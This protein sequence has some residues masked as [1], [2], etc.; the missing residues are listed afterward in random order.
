MKISRIRI[1][2]L[3]VIALCQSTSAQ[4]PELDSNKNEF[5]IL[6]E[7]QLD[8]P[9]TATAN[10]FKSV[11][12]FAAATP[13]ANLNE[14]GQ[15]IE[16]VP[17]PKKAGVYSL[18]NTLVG[19]TFYSRQSQYLFG[20]VIEPPVTDVNDLMFGK[21]TLSSLST[22]ASY[23]DFAS[24]GEGFTV[25]TVGAVPDPW[26]PWEYNDGQWV[27]EGSVA[28]NVTLSSLSFNGASGTVTVSSALSAGGSGDHGLTTGET[29]TIS[30]ASPSGY[31]GTFDV[32]S[33]TGLDSFTFVMD[34]SPSEV[35][36]LKVTELK[37]TPSVTQTVGKGGT[38]TDPVDEGHWLS[39]EPY[40]YNGHVAWEWWNGIGGAGPITLLSDNARY[41]DSPDGVTF[42]PSWNTR[43][44][45]A[46]G[47]ESNGRDNYGGR[48]S[49]ILTAP[50]TGTYRFFVASDD[51]SVL[52]ISTD[53]DPANAVQ[54]AQETGCCKNFTLDDG[55]LSGTVNL[56]AGNQ[57]YM[58]ALLKEGSGG[59]WMTVGWR[60]PSED[61]DD[62]PAG[63]QEGIPGEYFTSTVNVQ[64]LYVRER[65][66]PDS[67][68][69]TQ[70]FFGF[71]LSGIDTGTRLL[72][73]RL[74]VHQ[75]NKI[76]DLDAVGYASDL[77]LS[78][79]SAAWD[80]EGS[81]YPIFETTTTEDAF[82]IGNDTQFGVPK[83]SAG[84]FGGD[85]DN[86]ESDDGQIDVTEFVQ[87][88]LENPDDNHGFRLRM[89]DKSFTGATFSPVDNPETGDNEE[90]RLIITQS[91]YGDNNATTAGTLTTCRDAYHDF[92]TSPNYVVA[93]AGEVTLSVE[94][95]HAFEADMLDSGQLW[96]SVNGRAYADVE[97]DAFSANGYTNVAIAGNGIAKGENGFGGTSA[98]YADGSYITTT[99][100]LGTFAAGDVISVRFV[101]LYGDCATG[102]KPNWVIDKVAFSSGASGTVTAASA[103]V[104]AV[105]ASDHGLS[106]G[107]AFTISGASPSSYNGTF[108][109]ASNTGSDSFIFVMDSSPSNAITAGTLT[110]PAAST[111]PYDYWR[112]KPHNAYESDLPTAV[113]YGRFYWSDNSE[114]LYATR[115]GPVE[116]VWVRK[117]PTLGNPITGE[118]WSHST[119]PNSE[120]LIKLHT[121]TVNGVTEMWSE[122]TGI[123]YP[124]VKKQVIISGSSVKPA[125]KIYWTGSQHSGVPVSIPHSRISD[126]K[127]IFNESFPKNVPTDEAEVIFEP[128]IGLDNSKNEGDSPTTSGTPVQTKTLWY[129]KVQNSINAANKEGRVFVELLGTKKAGAKWKQSLGFEIVD[130]IKDPTLQIESVELGE[131]FP[132]L[133]AIGKAN[134]SQNPNL[135]PTFSSTTG[136]RDFVNL[137]YGSNPSSRATFYAVKETKND[138]DLML[139]WLAE[140]L[141]GIK[142]PDRYVEYKLYW[143]SNPNKY[144]HYIRPAVDSEADAKKTA[145]QLPSGNSPKIAYQDDAASPRAKLDG[146]F[147]FYTYL[148]T[149]YPVHRTLLKYSSNDNLEF[150][151]VFSWLEANIIDNSFPTNTITGS[152]GY[153]NAEGS[154][155]PY[156]EPKSES[157]GSSG[158]IN[159]PDSLELETPRILTGS[160]FVGEA[161]TT[162]ESELGSGDQENYLAAYINKGT[163]YDPVSYKNPFTEGFDEA[164][165]GAVIPVNAIPG[166]NSLEV[167]WFRKNTK[168]WL[169]KVEMNA[170][171]DLAQKNGFKDVY[172]PSVIATYTIKWPHEAVGYM[173]VSR[174]NA[175]VMA[176]NDGSGPLNSLQAKGSLYFQNNITLPGHNPNEE[177]AIMQ[178]GQVYALRN[179]L[180][181]TTETYSSSPYVLLNYTGADGR[182]AMRAFH[183]LQ[184]LGEDTFDY[185][186]EAGTILQAPMPLPLMQK[187]KDNSEFSG[188]IITSATKIGATHSLTLVTK[189][190]HGFSA[191]D[192]V[193]LSQFS[194][195]ALNGWAYVDNVNAA[196]IEAT[197]MYNTRIVPID[198]ITNDSGTVTVVTKEAH[199]FGVYLP[200]PR[201]IKIVGV[202]GYTKEYDNTTFSTSGNELVITADASLGNKG[203][204][205]HVFVLPAA[206]NF[207]NPS[208]APIDIGSD[209]PPMANLQQSAAITDYLRSTIMDRKN[210]VWVY[211]GPHTPSDLATFRMRY[212]YKTLKGFWFPSLGADQL[213]VG[214]VVPYLLNNKEGA[215]TKQDYKPRVA[216]GITYNAIWPN[217]V[218]EL[219]PGQTLTEPVFGLPAVRG[220]TSLKLLYQ[221]SKAQVATDF[222]ATLHDPTREKVYDLA[223]AATDLSELPSSAATYSSKGKT[224]FTHLPPHLVERFFFDPNR[225]NKGQL[226]LR[227]EFVDEIVGEDYLLMNVLSGKDLNDLKKV[228]DPN[229]GIRKWNAAIN[230]LTAKVETFKE[231]TVKAGVFVVDAAKTVNVTAAN[232]V[233]IVSDET[234]VDSYALTANGNKYGYVTLIAGNS[235]AHTPKAEPVQMHVI[236]IDGPLYRGEA[237]V[238]LSDNPL[239]E[240]VTLM[241]TGDMGGATNQF[242]YD[243]RIASPE[244]GSPPDVSVR[245]A[246]NSP[247]STSTIINTTEWNH[248]SRIPTTGVPPDG[249]VLWDATALSGSVTVQ[250]SIEA[251]EITFNP[252]NNT[253][254]I[255]IRPI[256][257]DEGR[258]HN[259]KVGDVVD[260]VGFIPEI[261][262]EDG[263]TVKSVAAEYPYTITLTSHSVTDLSGLVVQKL[264]IVEES[265][266]GT[267]ISSPESILTG[268][269]QI[270]SGTVPTDVYLSMAVDPNLGVR[271]KIGS[272]VVAVKNVSSIIDGGP[273]DSAVS[274]AP[275]SFNTKPLVYSVDTSILRHNGGVNKITVELWGKANP[276]A[277]L[278][279]NLQLDGNKLED[280]VSDGSEWISEQ[281]MANDLRSIVIGESADIRALSDNYLVMRYQ[282]TDSNH[283]TWVDDDDG[284]NVGWSRWTEPQLA[285]GWIKRVLAGINPFNQRAGDLY[286][287]P[288]RM[289]ASM[290]TQA[291]KRWEGDVALNMDNINDYGLIEIYETVLGRGR[292]LSIDAGIDFGPANDAL[293]LA[294]GYLN[295]LYMLIGNEAWADAA[296]PTIGIGTND[297]AYGDIATALFAF[298]GQ[299]PSLLEEEL[300]LLRGRDDFHQPGVETGPVYN[301]LF[302]NYTRGIDAGEVIYSLNYDIKENIDDHDG[303]IDAADAY[304]MYPQGHGD[305]YGHYLTA[306]KGYYKL[307]VD[308][309][310]TWV[311]RVEAVTILGKAVEV[312]YTDERKFAAAA[313]AA[314]RAG[315]EIVDLTWRKDYNADKIIV[316]DKEFSPSRENN[317]RSPATTRYW[318]MDHWASRVGQGALINWVVGNSMLP[319]IDPDPA[320]EGIEKIDR[321][322]V[323]E[324]SELSAVMNTVQTTMDNAEAGMNPLGLNENSV[325]MDISPDK[326]THFEQIFERAENA[327]NNATIAFDSAKDVTQLMRSE[328]DSLFDMEV[329]VEEQELAYKFK[330]IELYGTPYSGD[331]GPGKTYKQG[332]DGPDLYHHMYVDDLGLTNSI[333]GVFQPEQEQTFK[334]D[335]QTNPIEMNKA[336]NIKDNIYGGVFHQIEGGLLSGE[337]NRYFA[338]VQKNLSWEQY[339]ARN[340]D[341]YDL[342][343][344]DK[345]Y[346]TYTVSPSGYPI[347]PSDWGKRSTVGGLQQAISA[348]R[349][350]RNKLSGVL[351]AHERKKYDLDRQIEVF[352]SNVALKDFISKVKTAKA[353][354]LGV[355][356]A[357][358]MTRYTTE[359]TRDVALESL[360]GEYATIL[361]EIT[362]NTVIGMSTGGDLLASAKAA[363][364]AAE[365]AE[366]VAIIASYD[367]VAKG[368]RMLEDAKKIA[369]GVLDA[370]VG[371]ETKQNWYKNSVLPLDLKLKELNSSLYGIS[372][373]M[374]S[375]SGARGRYRNLL[376]QGLRIQEEREMFRQNTAVVVQSFRSK[377]AAFRI[378]RNEKLERYKALQETAAKYAF[379][380]AQAYDYET[381]LLGT[382]E[383]RMFINRIIN[384]RALGVVVNGKPQ[385]AGSDTGDPGISSVLAEMKNDWNVIKGR[386]GFNNP[387]Q[388]AT[389]LSLRNEKHRILPGQEGAAQWGDVLERARKDN[390]LNDG[391][392]RRYCMNVGFEDGRP[393]PGLVIEFSTT[394]N[395]GENVFGLPIVGGDNQFSSSSFA[396]K[397]WSAGIAFEGYVGMSKS[398][399]ND[400]GGVSPDN[401]TPIWLDPTALAKNPYVYLIPVGKDFMRSPP[402]GDTSRIR[403]WS[404][405][406]VAVPLPFNI[407]NSEYSSK[408]FWQSSN[409]LTEELFGIRKHQAFRALDSFDTVSPSINAWETVFD[410]S[411]T[412]RRLIGRSVWNSKW[413]I[414]IPGYTLLNDPEE[415][416]DRFIE[417]VDDIK[418]HF[419]TYSY[420]GN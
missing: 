305:S 83:N 360:R 48:M 361:H 46:G 82:I 348:V 141:Q 153:T 93:A 163:S 199:G 208:E 391:D 350:E 411:A 307:I 97:K 6:F 96:I 308:N 416:L 292:M 289:A 301:R 401:P 316:W 173:A 379:L 126:I 309:D 242:K 303:K 79:V 367:A 21:V 118:G 255:V 85:P 257:L 325:A 158:K 139:W 287:N 310:F 73:A 221:Q 368:I 223:Q 206:E 322:T 146:E 145:V 251:S 364:T 121:R 78:R 89:T 389:S 272:A 405:N 414:V 269:F 75:M 86:P 336:G 167:I 279:F 63:N 334:I 11:M 276:G 50:E 69:R 15:I 19:G 102:A 47:F 211:R 409:S 343:P 283:V 24:D 284:N 218:A 23:Y 362:D 286:T 230:G 331:I 108:V 119:A 202:D 164:N 402:L 214:T 252:D 412:N 176:S 237:K 13:G 259:F 10:Q 226:V 333:A 169:N 3:F 220:N 72:S 219:R 256:R 365:T 229:M 200:L 213:S 294:A 216:L 39:G 335:L 328:T 312:D 232:L 18:K 212:Y 236:K 264:G 172:W 65:S 265:V 419:N 134:I 32:A 326:G 357:L 22:S 253:S 181:D 188:S 112:A 155:T 30:G 278:L 190:D 397:I 340:A 31:N 263:L 129:S 168:R 60:K 311:P 415:G 184:E 378:F 225:G 238:I 324:L 196:E 203:V 353:I 9:V 295:D 90:L 87:Y 420:S 182:P 116:I 244:D 394:I 217:S 383:G 215:L 20:A 204:G 392:V 268:K 245:T 91:V 150:E 132:V 43:T 128:G 178:G 231:S 393:V 250:E 222:S 201:K 366:R 403:S 99:A 35:T 157:V 111:Q 156:F 88:W 407:G 67:P 138:S 171:H 285:E 191:N 131:P 40:T 299:V 80:T 27:S 404:V 369:D 370:S 161:L 262:N 342:T 395:K 385:F 377:D 235:Q 341:E 296:N 174:E 332:W 344:L 14:D 277:K 41:P 282:A 177:H 314:A 413:K 192:V 248:L 280:K 290:L 228:A 142:W 227:G 76:N 44:A 52:R 28:D 327:L 304:V 406:D 390:I 320:H 149:S 100:S 58:E 313:A 77:E 396:T 408:K 68:L 114:A 57:Y 122:E 398:N 37:P 359:D 12:S 105:S 275:E 162:P 241:H 381:G 261:V 38:A 323:P 246:I 345:N 321:T 386:L 1:L 179:D 135:F 2:F 274:N 151:R 306:L 209:N 354:I 293:L 291:G 117:Q 29:F 62:V 34:S 71:D 300:A 180:N 51:A 103:T 49:G 125:R 109:V 270:P 384:S 144:S 271:V 298:K 74:V 154:F 42:V 346:I 133:Q 297:K 247:T 110:T 193:Y 66:E 140:G 123:F 170:A 355:K 380:A 330:L 185:T 166:A 147:K 233:E 5:N 113:N 240:K 197:Q 101:A 136:G 418:I 130:V 317:K 351:Q 107:D 417:S 16:V 56:V 120:D 388:Y 194:E 374:L 273:E 70:L 410:R 318:G 143:P 319:A 372:D 205:G 195:T 363:A 249:D 267:S 53:T 347:K 258:V 95:R 81:N 254:T 17:E 281:D 33:T 54:V 64:A 36:E 239:A 349:R 106:S 198:S 234:A 339:G 152:I 400:Q 59:D 329:A 148:E 124:A 382:D 186:V 260:L 337:D 160:I 98:G 94:H 375:Y 4:V 8:I 338:M 45:L 352:E 115:G 175:I 288:T 84:F 7:T 127:I 55:G 387:D 376:A 315:N 165:K 104:T 183:V 224:Y 243:W 358:K 399:T 26:G 189:I 187:L 159:F 207:T 25:E 373:A 92:L 137:H 356:I 266:S 210:N 371:H 302:W 61:I